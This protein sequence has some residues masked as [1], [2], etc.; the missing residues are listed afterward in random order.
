[1]GRDRFYK[2]PPAT[3]RHALEL[4]QAIAPLERRLLLAELILQW[5]I[6]GAARRARLPDR[7]YTSAALGLADDLARPD[8]RHDDAASELGQLTACADDLDPLAALAAF[9]KIAPNR[10]RHCSERNASNRLRAVTC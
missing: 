3:C 8:G 7:Q 2:P 5:Q 10:G 4:P 6:A 1:M 9:L